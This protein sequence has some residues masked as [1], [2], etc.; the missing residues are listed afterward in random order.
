MTTVMMTILLRNNDCNA[1]HNYITDHFDLLI[2]LLLVLIIMI[3]GSSA[4][5]IIVI[6]DHNITLS[7]ELNYFSFG[8]STFHRWMLIQNDYYDNCDL[9]FYSLITIL[10]FDVS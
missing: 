6:F 9:F 8:R 1:Y 10:P 2:K 5:S 3:I 4:G 7:C